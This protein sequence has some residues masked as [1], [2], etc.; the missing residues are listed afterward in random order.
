MKICKYCGTKMADSDPKCFSCGA[1]EFYPVHEVASKGHSIISQLKTAPKRIKIVL[2]TCLTLIVIL[3]CLNIYQLLFPNSGRNLQTTV[4]DFGF[5]NIGKLETQSS[6]YREIIFDESTITIYN[7]SV[8]GTKRKT[9]ATCDGEIKAGIDFTAIEY[10]LDNEQKIIH[11]KLPE[12]EV[13]SNTV[14]HESLKTLDEQLNPFNPSSLEVTNELFIEVARL[15]QEHALEKGLLVNA[16][17][18]AKTIVKYTC[19]SVLPDYR[20]IFE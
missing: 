15:G 6:Y 19:L 1:E 18:H 13:L 12:A 2:Y 10:S 14:D 17:E 5:S 9:I 20:V 4:V 3:I 16:S 8:P 11:I 7:F